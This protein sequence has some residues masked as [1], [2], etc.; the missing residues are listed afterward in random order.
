M[1]LFQESV[2]AS[3]RWVTSAVWSQVEVF[4][5]PFC[6]ICLLGKWGGGERAENRRINGEVKLYGEEESIFTCCITDFFHLKYLT[7]T[8]LMFLHYPPPHL[9]YSTFASC[10]LSHQTPSNFCTLCR[11]LL[12]LL[13]MRCIK[14]KHLLQGQNENYM[15]CFLLQT[16]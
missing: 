15:R 2:K 11:Q 3:T 6:C 8:N 14:I 9:Y 4:S 10:G 7:N 5:Q 1:L 12:Q 13:R 16:A